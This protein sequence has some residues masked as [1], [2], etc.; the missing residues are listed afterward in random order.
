[1]ATVSE[2]AA[3]TPPTRLEQLEREVADFRSWGI[4]EVAI[5]NPNVAEYMEHWEGRTL[6]AEAE[7]A[8]LSS[9]LSACRE[10]VESLTRERDEA[11]SLADWHMR[12]NNEHMNAVWA[13]L[14]REPHREGGENLIGRITELKAHAEA[15]EARLSACR[16][17]LRRAHQR[18]PNLETPCMGGDNL[19]ICL[20]SFF[21]DGDKETEDDTGWSEAARTGYQEV[22]EAIR[23][24]Y[25]AAL[26]ASPSIR[27]AGE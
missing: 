12:A 27:E 8:R 22:I 11:Q 24:H 1:M 23:A 21:D 26:S 20:C 15:A 5:R 10:Q 4:I 2:P 18:L 3:A 13:V 6:K 14:G 7:I 9:E 25:D 19:A 17:A 16:E